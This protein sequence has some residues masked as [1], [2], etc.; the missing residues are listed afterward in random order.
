[1]KFA[2]ALAAVLLAAGTL[3]AASTD[4]PAE[5]LVVSTDGGEVAVIDKADATQVFNAFR[6]SSSRGPVDLA[7][8][9]FNRDGADDVVA[10][11][12]GSVR[13]FDA[14]GNVHLNFQPYPGFLGGVRVAT[15]DVSG[16]GIDDI[17]T[18]TGPGVSGGH[19]KVFTGETLALNFT[20][21]VFES[22]FM[23]GVYVA[24]G[25]IDGDG[26]AD[27]IVGAGAGGGPHV[28]VFSGRTG[29]LHAS[30]FAYDPAFRGGVRVGAGDVDGDGRTDIITG[31]GPGVA[32][33]HVRVF[34]GLTLELLASFQ[35]FD[36]S[37]EGGLFIAGDVRAIAVTPDSY[38]GAVATVRLFQAD[39]D[40]QWLMPFPSYKGG[41][42][43]A[44][45]LAS[46][47]K[48]PARPKIPGYQIES[49]W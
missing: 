38:S 16:D 8:L 3:S 47:G 35:P 6:A 22:E 27:I 36:S 42:R 21:I 46:W 17:V 7:V 40:V 4:W 23:G 49:T 13:V 32:G 19:V 12:D 44:Q 45:S 41:F 14:G 11:A 1:M 37:Y 10:G 5:I 39:A 30:F 43:V 2:V 25:D 28:K 29:E 9:D 48:V 31:A 20:K 33:P 34:S 26:Y 15:G 24:A 18:G